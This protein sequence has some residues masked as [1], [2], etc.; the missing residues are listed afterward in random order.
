MSTTP[1]RRSTAL[2]VRRWCCVRRRMH[3][4]DAQRGREFLRAERLRAATHGIRRQHVR[5]LSA[6]RRRVAQ[7]LASSPGGLPTNTKLVTVD[8][9]DG[10]YAFTFPVRPGETRF[11]VAYTLPYSG[12]QPFALKLSVPTGDVAVML[13]KSMQFQDAR[14]S[15]STIPASSIRRATTHIS[16]HLRSRCSS[17]SVARGQL[18]EAR[19]RAGRRASRPA[20]RPGGLRRVPAVRVPAAGWARRAILRGPTIRGRSTSGGFSPAL[21]WLWWWARESC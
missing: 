1:R 19:R 14:S 2:P 12:K 3:G 10:H 15:R 11:Q 20:A 16:R 4:Q 21:D 18:P 5:L 9:A 6:Q 7:T 13:P 17:P 8:A